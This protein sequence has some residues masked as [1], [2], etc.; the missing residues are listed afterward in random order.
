MWVFGPYQPV[1][2]WLETHSEVFGPYQPV[3]PWSIPACLALV[4]RNPRCHH[5]TELKLLK[6]SS[7]LASQKCSEVWGGVNPSSPHTP[8][9]SLGVAFLVDFNNHRLTN[10]RWVLCPTD[11][12]KMDEESVY[13]QARSDDGLALSVMCYNNKM[14]RLQCRYQ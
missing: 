4:R 13:H 1:L 12:Q 9:R 8:G 3:L 5:I 11:D 2:P 10:N 6:N 14:L 7:A